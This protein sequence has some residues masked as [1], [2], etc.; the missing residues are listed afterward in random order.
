MARL[1][2]DEIRR[3]LS[4]LHKQVTEI[5]LFAALEEEL[6]GEESEA[7]LREPELLVY[8]PTRQQQIVLADDVWS[9][10][11]TQHAHLRMVQRGIKMPVVGEIFS[12]FVE[13]FKTESQEIL[14]DA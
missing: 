7:F 3:L 4:Y 8:F 14:P 1:R 11:I 9:L 6:L 10:Q 13:Y 12:R 2:N 5:E